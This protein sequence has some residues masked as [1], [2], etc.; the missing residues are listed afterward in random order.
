MKSLAE[1]YPDAWAAIEQ[2]GF[3]NLAEMARRMDAP[4][5]MDAAL[6]YTSAA[7]KWNR[8]RLPGASAERRA[9]EW[10]SKTS[11]PSESEMLIVVCPDGASSKARRLLTVLG[12][13][14]EAL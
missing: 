1:Q 14:V 8:G 9:A 11:A 10:L 3:T 4:G 13:E 7:Q 2:A 5:A 12:C 6:G